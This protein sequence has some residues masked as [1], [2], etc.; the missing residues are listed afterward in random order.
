M[1][2]YITGVHIYIYIYIYTHTHTHTRR[3]ADR[4]YIQSVPG[5]KVNILG[6]HS[7]GRSMQKS[8]HVSNPER[9]PRYSHFAV[10]LQ[11]S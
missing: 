7:I 5:E 10:Q 6:G 4:V 8:V 9:L 3:V 2:G 11:N 1:T